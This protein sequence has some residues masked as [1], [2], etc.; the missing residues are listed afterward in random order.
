[1]RDRIIETLASQD[2]ESRP[3]WKPMHQQPIYADHD[4][5]GRGVSDELFARGICRPTGSALTDEDQH[6][7]I[8]GIQAAI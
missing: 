1:M 6:R 2:I 5:V 7:V 8:E 4:Y 3:L